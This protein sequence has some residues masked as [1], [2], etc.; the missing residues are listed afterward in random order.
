MAQMARQPSK[1]FELLTGSVL[2][3]EVPAVNMAGLFL[4]GGFQSASDEFPN[5]N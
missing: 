4:F 3:L 5:S 2:A 1:G